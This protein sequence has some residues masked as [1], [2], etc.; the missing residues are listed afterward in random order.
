MQDCPAAWFGC[1]IEFEGLENIQEHCHRQKKE[2][3]NVN[4]CAIWSSNNLNI[5]TP[6]ALNM[7]TQGKMKHTKFPLMEVVERAN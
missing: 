6:L 3:W 1:K 2:E 7:H 4:T 5:H